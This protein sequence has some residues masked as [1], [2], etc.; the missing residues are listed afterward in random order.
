MDGRDTDPK[1]GKGFIEQ[2]T[3]HCEKSAGKIACIVGRLYAMDRDK[4]WER[5]MVAYD[6]LVDGEG[7]V[8][9][10]MVQAMQAVSYT[11][12]PMHCQTGRKGQSS[13][14]NR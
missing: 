3:A 2:L 8:A 12:L 14:R 13:Y 6:L 10:D 9:T 1:S 4:R 11:H 5:V 7:K